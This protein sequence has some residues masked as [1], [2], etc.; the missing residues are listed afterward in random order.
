MHLNFHVLKKV[1]SIGTP[2]KKNTHCFSSIITHLSQV[3]Y[4]STS[5]C[6]YNLG[7]V[8]IHFFFC[9]FH[10]KNNQQDFFALKIALGLNLIFLIY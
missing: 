5:C 9:S 3:H 1:N 7:I 10:F 6:S 2:H 8:I 4:Y